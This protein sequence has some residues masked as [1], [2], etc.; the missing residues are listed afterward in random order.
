MKKEQG[1]KGLLPQVWKTGLMLMASSMMTMSALA[2]PLNPKP[3]KVDNA[4]ETITI[5]RLGDEHFRYTMSADGRLIGQDSTGVYYYLNEDGQLSDVKVRSQQTDAENQVL[6]QIDADKVKEAYRKSHPMKHMRP[7]TATFKPRA[8]AKGMTETSG[9]GSHPVMRMPSGEHCTGTT[10]RFP[11]LLVAGSGS[12]NCDVTE[13]TNRLNQEGYSKNS[14]NG[15]VRDYFKSASNGKF[16]PTY[17]VYAVTV[18]NSLSS[19]VNNEHKLVKEAIAQLKSNYP[20][21]DATQYDSDNDGE[22]DALG[23]LYAGTESAANNLGGYQYELQWTDSGMQTIGS[24]KFNN[25]LIIAQMESSNTLLPIATFCHEFSHTMGLR[26]HYSV[27]NYP[28]TFTT[29]FP[30]SHAWDVMSTGMYANGGACPPGYSAFEKDF[31]GWIT[32]T[33]FTATD[34]T[35][36]ITPL[37]TTNMAYKLVADNDEW[38][39]LENRQLTGWDK[40]LPNSGMLIWHIDYDQEPWDGDV[41]NDTED[42]QRIDVVEAGNLKVESYYDGFEATHQ[43]DDPFP[44]S[45]NV[46]TFSSFKSWVGKDLGIKL[47]NITEKNNNIY[48]TTNANVS[49]DTNTEAGS[50]ESGSTTT[51]TTATLQK[52]GAG[53]SS[54]TITIGDAI[55]D[56]G[57]SWTEAT[58]ATVTGLPNGVTATVNT[59]DKTI[60]ISG[61]PTEIGTFSFTVT[62]TGATTNA[63]KTGTITVNEAAVD[64]IT[65]Q[66]NYNVD[67]TLSSNYDPD[68]VDISDVFNWLGV[69]NVNTLPSNLYSA[70]TLKEYGVEPSGSLNSNMTANEPGQWYDAN[71]NVSSYNNGYVYAEYTLDQSIVRIGHY[72]DKVKADDS[73]TISQAFVYGA[74]K[75][76]LTFNI[77]LKDSTS[78]SVDNIAATAQ[79]AVVDNQLVMHNM[80]EGAKSVKIYSALGIELYAEAF[81]ESEKTVDLNCLGK[82]KFAIVVTEGQ[83]QPKMVVKVVR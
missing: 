24:K 60:S 81:N 63:T 20:N 33:T 16:A 27:Q 12:T 11:V 31:M 36:V 29:Q 51:E 66:F 38:Y 79:V 45:Q 35:T 58:N 8:W 1:K 82:N 6:N 15:S 48:F 42:H 40:Y 7:D 77:K 71:G 21:F 4:G 39:Y 80:A 75:A 43:V 68:T 18:S 54:Q 9:D 70:G 73:Y 61:T 5:Q 44:G 65:K 47:Y 32:P 59:N 64:T 49:V 56:F 41:M 25:F 76:I 34:G 46:T 30:G 69:Y 28:T 55:A 83:N 2:A 13:M 10:P 74:N 50:S 67:L 22:I 53:S 17:D 19:Y 14:H 57:Y 62:T 23:V 26:D 37:N 78:A 3:I 52:T 72:P